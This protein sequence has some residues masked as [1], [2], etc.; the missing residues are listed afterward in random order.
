MNKIKVWDLPLRLF[1]WTLAIAVAGAYISENFNAMDWHQYFG[2]TIAGLLGFRV[3]WGLL[4]SHH[5]RFSSFLPSPRKL[6][7]Y[8]T[9]QWQGEGHNPL[10]A[11]AVW[12]LLLVVAAQLVTGLLGNDDSSFS[13]P[14]AELIGKD[15]SDSLTALHRNLGWALLGL[16]GLHVAAVIFY[17]VVR[18]HDLLTP[19]IT[20]W[21]RSQHSLT[22]AISGS[23]A[24]LVLAVGVA[25]LAVFFASGEWI[26]EAPAAPP[27]AT[28]SF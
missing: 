21:K 24:G 12:A 11:L 15:R 17:L 18:R 20:G 25:A 5:A 13:G 2:L 8:L 14:L 1:H 22:T 19:M 28:P 10:G 9:G 26:A 3:I 23:K 7:A 16:I 6:R 4:G 27:V